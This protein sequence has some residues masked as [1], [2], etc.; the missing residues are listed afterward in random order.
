MFDL[1]GKKVLLGVTGSI[2]AY[3]SV[4]LLRLLK[5]SGA[6]VKVL[7]TTSAQR[8]VG[9]LTFEALSGYEVID[10]S[11][12]SWA[13]D[14]NHIALAKWADILVIAP[15]TANTINKLS[16]GICDNILTQCAIA[17]TKPKLI[18]PSANVNM[19]ENPIT[20]ASL[21]M[22]RLCGYDIVSS[23]VKMLACNIEANGAMAE[24]LEIY[25]HIAQGLLK[26][27]FWTNRRVVV[28]SGG[29]REK[30]DDV[31]YISNFSSGKMGH[32]I[33]L[34]LF[35]LGADV[36]LVTTADAK[37]IPKAIHTIAV[38]DSNSMQR[39]LQDSL[40]VAKKGVLSKVSLSDERTHP[41]LIQKTPYLFMVSAVSDYVPSFVQSG[42]IKKEMLGKT[43]NLS[44]EQNMDILSS[45][46]K[47][48][49]ICVGFKAEMDAHN[50]KSNAKKMLQ[51]KKLQAVCLNILKDST[52][53]GKDT[54]E[55]TFLSYDK[56]IELRGDKIA[57]SF[58]IA[59]VCEDLC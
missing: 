41:E 21:K 5:K 47:E 31:R 36:C 16:N 23:Q 10:E 49:V 3:K 48:G 54:N 24:P 18:A 37:E 42:K 35:C 22:L 4:E 43:W 2:A 13:N 40:R 8:F 7:A 26:T 6:D 52:D 45:L 9:K 33:A 34:A 56:D 32:S 59:K 1:S 46:E 53:F 39:Y 14:N 19:L 15:A 29:T 38:D 12:E 28:S 25:Y 55:I 51:A 17:C 50:A 11:S 58:D 57:L 30:I 27:D 20:E 44:L